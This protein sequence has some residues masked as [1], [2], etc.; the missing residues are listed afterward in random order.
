MEH[1]D[2]PVGPFT[3]TVRADGPTDGEPVLLLHGFPQT[4]YAWRYQLAALARAGYRAVAPDQR[5]YSPGARPADVS[6]YHPERLVEDVIGLADALGADRFH[7]VGHDFG[8]LVAWHTAARHAD[9]LATLTVVSTPHPRAVARSILEGGEQREKSSYMLFF[10]SSDAE[11]FF[12]D[13]DAAG[14][15]DLFSST[16][17][18]DIDDYVAVLTQPGAMTAALNWYRALDRDVIERMGPITSP[19]LFA[20]STDDP[21]LGRVAAEETAT[22]VEGPYRFE[23]LEGVGHFVPE[24]VPDALSRLVVDHV[25]ATG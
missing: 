7:L 25:S 14:L 15:R 16:G 2:V 19:T 1:L 5:G 8:G 11:P 6:E 18:T 21:A 9:R 3:F 24:E 23:V 4:S 13:D 17:I 12:L 10:R 22:H 20:W